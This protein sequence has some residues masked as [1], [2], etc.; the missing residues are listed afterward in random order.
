MDDLAS[1]AAHVEQG[2]TN[3][4]R[5]PH[6]LFA[7]KDGDTFVVADAY[8]DILGA[9]DGLFHDDTRVLSYFRLLLGSK[10][11]SLLS[12]AIAQDNV[13]FTS[14]GTNL[15]L[16]PTGAAATP[17][18]V[19]HLERKRFLWDGRL[20][21]RIRFT[22][23]SRDPA[24]APLAF[25]YA[26]DF[27]DMFEV[28]GTHREQ[29]GRMYQ[30]E[31]GGR[32]VVFRYDGLDGVSR[33][34]AIVFSE[35]PARLTAGRAEFNLTLPPEG[36]VELYLE[37]G[38]TG[39]EAG[40][41]DPCQDRFRACAARA[42]F[43]MRAKRRHGAR[44]KT[45]GRLFN[46][47]IEK[48]RSDLSLLITD[49]P[50]GPYPYAGIPWFSTEFGRDAIITAWQVL[51]I[52]ASLARGVLAYLAS[53]QATETSKFRDSQPGKIMHETRKG[54][55]T[56]LGELP[57]GRYYGGGDTTPL[58]VALAGAYADRTGDLEFIDRLWP[59]LLAAVN[60]MD[61]YGDSNGD[62]LI[63]YQRGEDSGL[64]NQG[65]KDSQDSVFH[66]DGSFP[67]GPIALVEVQ[68]YAFAAYRA[69]ADLGERRGD[70]TSAG[71]WRLKAEAIRT[72]VEE[73]F[74]MEEEGTYGIAIDG[75]GQLCRV[76]SSNPG[77][78]LFCG[79]PTPDRA[80][81]VCAQLVSAPFQSGWGVRTLATGEARFNPMS[82]HNGSVWPHD[83]ALCVAGMAR[84]GERR[85]VI[86]ML[87]EVFE[88][89]VHF[90]MRLP[91]LFCGFPRHPGE[92]PV[93]YPVACL[94]QAWA[95]GSIFM[96]L[97]ACLGIT[98]DGWNTEIVIDHPT[99][100]IGIDSLAI[101]NLRVGSSEATLMFQ[102]AGERVIAVPGRRSDSAIAV[103]TRA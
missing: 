53:T 92:P 57:F 29:R 19:I 62:G 84:Y 18:G 24:L 74:W 55:M 102:H 27:H 70:T 3:E 22:N 61:E 41:P 66:A 2:E 9:A 45:S 21:E 85:A 101:D 58:F 100:P 25:E 51:W 54:E 80:A 76:C 14:N 93:A 5:V 91:E 7:L 67:E 90:E 1:P 23:Y 96:L 46:E 49:L 11:P 36:S 8:G 37:V 26:A 33:S 52:N 65:W 88:T 60:W 75:K 4:P 89:A 94:P 12:A 40:G 87:S 73:R 99:L 63:D 68:G 32:R 16:A 59:S 15:P 30:P 83:T 79:L 20:Y 69:M 77:H 42:R 56:T 44:I 50:T 13:F 95:A 43:A 78:L 48:S 28:R 31:V 97:Q 71:R 72:A 103:I 10:P 64:T 47:W 34:S 86:Q 17:R 98:V 81:R 6:R 82:Y 38:A 39:D 35:Q